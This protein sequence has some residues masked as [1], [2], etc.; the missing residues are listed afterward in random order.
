M[1]RLFPILIFRSSTGP[2]RG[3]VES[4]WLFYVTFDPPRQ[5]FEVKFDGGGRS[6]VIWSWAISIRI[7]IT[8]GVS[9]HK[10]KFEII[11]DY[12][13]FGFL[14]NQ[15]FIRGCGGLPG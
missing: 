3:K 7:S 15:A 4:M 12:I 10:D 9:V 11:D 5:E 14:D 6:K 1:Y 8:Q 2:A 13:R